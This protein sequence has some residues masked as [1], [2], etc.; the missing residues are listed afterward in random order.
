MAAPLMMISLLL[1]TRR[2]SPSLPLCV[3]PAR[4]GER[5]GG[6]DRVEGREEGSREIK[7]REGKGAW[8]GE[9]GLAVM[10]WLVGCR[11]G[12]GNRP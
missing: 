3:R 11:G 7:E 2:Q 6:R 4:E 10:S 5:Q 12:C 1:V 8:D 9:R